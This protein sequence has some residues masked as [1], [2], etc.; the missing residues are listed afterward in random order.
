MPP[1]RSASALVGI[2]L[3]MAPFSAAAV[4]VDDIVAIPPVSEHYVQR[5]LDRANAGRAQASTMSAPGGFIFTLFKPW[6][7]F[8]TTGAMLS[9][10]DTRMQVTDM[11]RDLLERTPC[12]HLDI[13]ILQSKTEKIRQEMHAALDA[14]KPFQ[15]MY[16]QHLVRFMNRRTEQ[17]IR[18]ATDP[19]YEDSTWGR[20]E[21]FDP[22]NPVW[23]CPEGV[24]GNT[25]QFTDD[26]LC[27]GE[28][29]TSFTTPSA[30]QAYGCLLPDSQNPLE[31]KLCPFHSDYLPPVVSGYGC[32][33][34]AM[35]EEASG[36]GAA[37]TLPEM[38]ALADLILK[39]DTF[40]TK[41]QAFAPLVQE[42][43]AMTGVS[44]EYSSLGGGLSRTHKT[45]NGCLEDINLADQIGATSLL[46]AIHAGSAETR[47]PFS[48]PK[49]EPWI[50]VRLSTLLQQ[51]GERRPQA[52]DLRY[53][54]EFPPGTERDAAETREEKK[55]TLFKA[56][57]WY[58]RTVFQS[59]NKFH[60]RKEAI[61][62]AA[63]QDNILQVR[64]V[65]PQMSIVVQR[66]SA[67]TNSHS[68]GVRAF[69]KG[70]AYYLRRSCIYR[71]CNARLD[72][73]LRIVF[74]NSCF[75]YTSGSYF[76][77]NDIYT[78][79]AEDVAETK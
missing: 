66:L 71:S 24:P 17:L 35:P 34:E 7:I 54:S 27:V 77:S 13:I 43:D 79:C 37:V 38:T 70:F 58:I 56:R 63:S 73:V 51:W 5:V 69:T 74:Q 64:E 12:L 40:I 23:C 46:Q 50:M 65:S 4:T 16:L 47:G 75:P 6:W 52:K 10:V 1:I 22:P 32:D 41:M 49:N 9:T 15:V 78:Q 62:L 21:M 55:V 33:L 30:C 76:G 8:Y 72:Q 68:Q 44:S 18:G 42:I 29:G 45:V 57:D 25:C 36:T 28:G 59:W 48:I 3:A 20:V 53:P 39:R 11:Q 61:P 14:G 2:I 67:L 60:G 19:L 31:G 26:A